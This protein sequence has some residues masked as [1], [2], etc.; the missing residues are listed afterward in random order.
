MKIAVICGSSRSRGNS[1]ALVERVLKDL[2]AEWIFLRDHH[3]LPIVDKRHDEEGFKPVDD[4]YHDVITRIMRHDILLFV[5]PLYWYGMSG[6]MKN[7]IDR[8]SHSLRDTRY[9]FKSAMNG[10]IAYVVI[11]GGD[12]ARVKGLPLVQQFQYIFDFMSMRFGGFLIGEGSRP[13]DVLRDGRALKEAEWLN[14][15][16]KQ[17]VSQQ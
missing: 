2:D 3:I 17:R 11:C 16:L 7:F 9:D 4:D 15:E 12:R 14:V 13:G 10:K 6:F 1:E 5:T 8:W